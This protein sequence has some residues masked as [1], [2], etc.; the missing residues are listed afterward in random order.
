MFVLQSK[1]SKFVPP[2][3]SEEPEIL[4]K[5]PRREEKLLLNQK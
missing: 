3:K 1:K 5:L 4:Q 2:E